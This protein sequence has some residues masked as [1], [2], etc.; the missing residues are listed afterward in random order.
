MNTL[1]WRQK[2]RTAA[3]VT[4]PPQAITH[5]ASIHP[6]LA[7]TL[8]ELAWV[9]GLTLCYFLTRGL[10]QGR[11]SD[12]IAHANDILAIEQAIHLAPE[13]ALQGLALHNDALMEG[14]NLFYLA[15]HLPVLITIAVWLYWTRPRAYSWFRNAFLL[16]A[17]CGL[18][19][20]V[21]LPV[22]PPRLVPGFADTL[23]LAG[24]D[25]D[26]SAVGPFYNPYAAMPSLHVGWAM[27]AGSALLVC[28]R[29]W[30]L[31]V[32][33]GLLPLLMTLTVLMTGNHYLLDAIAGV[34][35]ALVSLLATLLVSAATQPQVAARLRLQLSALVHHV[36]GL[37]LSLHTQMCVESLRRNTG[38]EQSDGP[39]SV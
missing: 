30:L 11:E 24:L 5:P 32:L 35:V 36:M 23:R 1:A 22:A 13:Q 2:R 16:S 12:A 6:T 15:G 14:A 31:K 18:A 25:V 26:G 9:L 7:H 33:G 27:L 17:L 37:A 20:Y 19:V 39:T 8:L 29:H 10:I 28:G 3:H 38:A 34:G 21:V 4:S